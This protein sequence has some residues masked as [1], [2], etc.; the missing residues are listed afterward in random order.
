MK[1]TAALRNYKPD[2]C[3]STRRDLLGNPPGV[4]GRTTK[5][6]VPPHTREGLTRPG[7]INQKVTRA[8]RAKLVKGRVP[9]ECPVPTRR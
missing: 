1:E 6:D 4:I 2:T 9:R 3:G 5:I 8:A 7:L